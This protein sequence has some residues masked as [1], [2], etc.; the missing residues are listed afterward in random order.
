[1]PRPNILA[2]VLA[3]GRGGRLEP[4]TDFRA[5]PAVP[6]AGVYRLIDIS[7]RAVLILVGP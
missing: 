7:L 2:L 3:G 5:K 6:F 4:L 1:M